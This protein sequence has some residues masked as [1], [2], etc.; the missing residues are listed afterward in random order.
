MQ[1]NLNSAARAARRWS[2]VIAVMFGMPGMVE[3][4]LHLSRVHY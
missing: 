3:S 4:L 2:G 1:R